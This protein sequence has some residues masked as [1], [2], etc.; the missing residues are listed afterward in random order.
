MPVMATSPRRQP[1]MAIDAAIA[2]ARSGA[3]AS[4]WISGA[5]GTG[6]SWFLPQAAD[7]GRLA[8]MGV[9]STGANADEAEQSEPL[10]SLLR[11]MRDAGHWPRHLAGVMAGLAAWA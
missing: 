5:P 6:K 4:L 9:V 2:S 8:G 1:L 10:V 7:A 11:G 3:G